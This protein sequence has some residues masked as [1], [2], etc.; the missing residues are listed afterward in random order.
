MNEKTAE[1]I[2]SEIEAA[3]RVR[4]IELLYQRAYSDLEAA[5]TIWTQKPHDSAAGPLLVHAQ[6]I[7]GE[8]Q[9]C[10]D[11]SQGQ[12]LPATLGRLYEYI[13]FTLMQIVVQR[14]ENNLGRLEEIQGLVGTLSDAWSTMALQQ[15]EATSAPAQL[16]SLVA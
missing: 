11:Y 6:R 8:L 9:R 15:R 16:E 10:L 2:R 7:V 12:A 14:S 4:L 3:D 1:Y 13:Q 5:R